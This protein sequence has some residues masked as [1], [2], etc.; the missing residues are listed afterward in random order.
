MHWFKMININK[1]LNS[2]VAGMVEIYHCSMIDYTSLLYLRELTL[3][4]Q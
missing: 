1:Q 3:N 4:S 2:L